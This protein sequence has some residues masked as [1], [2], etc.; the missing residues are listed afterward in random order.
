[1]TLRTKVAA[2]AVMSCSVKPEAGPSSRKAS[3]AKPT[4]M[5]PWSTS[6]ATR[7]A[8][9]RGQV[10]RDVVLGGPAAE[11]APLRP[12]VAPL[13]RAGGVRAQVALQPAG[14]LGDPVGVARLAG[15]DRQLHQRA[16]EAQHLVEGQLDAVVP[17]RGALGRDVE[18]LAREG[19]APVLVVDRDRRDRRVQVA[20]RGGGVAEVLPQA[21]RRA[22]DP[23]E[24]G[25]GVGELAGVDREDVAQRRQAPLARAPAA[26][27]PRPARA[28][29]AR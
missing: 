2:K 16:A 3:T 27:P 20:V 21:G 13:V 18:A 8:G 4:S 26:R 15:Q 17:H 23:G 7:V 12:G 10:A 28:G 1:M 22:D 14:D 5:C 25:E 29:R 9:L 6:S 24:A 19:L 11:E